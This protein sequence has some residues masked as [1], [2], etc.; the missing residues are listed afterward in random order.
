MVPDVAVRLIAAVALVAAACNSRA[1]DSSPSPPVSV[2]PTP[3]SVGSAPAP[4]EENLREVHLRLTRVATLQQ[5]IAMAVR[6][7]DPAL[8]F[9]QKTG[10]VV[11]LRGINDPQQVLDLSDEVSQGGEQGL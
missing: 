10:E 6:A 7:D 1:D 2:S 3:R 8:Y 11:V 9:A 4:D 5:P